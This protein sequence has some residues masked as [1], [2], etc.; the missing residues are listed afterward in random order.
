MIGGFIW[1]KGADRRYT[2][3]YVETGFTLP[4]CKEGSYLYGNC[5]EPGEVGGM[6][7]HHYNL[8]L[9]DQRY[10]MDDLESYEP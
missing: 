9:N 8:M 10:R 7:V 6:C 1:V 3:E 4:F 2:L 5:E